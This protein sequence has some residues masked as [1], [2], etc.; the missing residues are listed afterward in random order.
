LAKNK[1]AT[2]WPSRGR[3]KRNRKSR[4]KTTCTRRYAMELFPA[5]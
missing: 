2:P 5:A 1:E 4:K 3:A